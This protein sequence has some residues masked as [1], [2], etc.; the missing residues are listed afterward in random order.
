MI[1]LILLFVL[2]LNSLY[3][4]DR[5]STLK[6]YLDIFKSLSP[7]KN[8]HKIYSKDKEYINVFKY[9]S[10][11]YLVKNI[12]NADIILITN[13]SNLD[14]ILKVRNIKSILFTTNYHI[15]KNVNHIVGAFYW[16]KG[17]SQLLFI[18]DR[19]SLHNINLP[20]KYQDYMVDEL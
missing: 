8:I 9:S 6:I 17:R 1:K 14:Y 7:Y 20:S 3:A 18:K 13:N 4:L 15:L 10:K 2:S 11:I 19:L 12:K 5:N 16:R